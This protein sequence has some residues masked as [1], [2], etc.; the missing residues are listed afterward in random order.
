MKHWFVVTPTANPYTTNMIFQL[1][2]DII[3]SKHLRIYY[4]WKQNGLTELHYYA[5]IMKRDRLHR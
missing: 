4:Y 1:I 2:E 3:R 5:G